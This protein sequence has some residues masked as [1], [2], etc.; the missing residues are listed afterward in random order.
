[1]TI[2]KINARH[3]YPNSNPGGALQTRGMMGVFVVE[4]REAPAMVYASDGGD[5]TASQ[6]RIGVGL[7]M[8]TAFV[9]RAPQQ[10]C[11]TCSHVFNAPTDPEAFF[12]AIPYRGDGDSL[13]CGV[14]RACVHKI[15]SDS[16]LG[17]AAEHF[18][19]IFPHGVITGF[20]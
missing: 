10:Q 6:I 20:R 12:L 19:K 7:W 16:L 4:R 9:P 14:C 1:M 15:G 11:A 2:T 5:F 8:Q 13:V 18:K 17:R 3:L